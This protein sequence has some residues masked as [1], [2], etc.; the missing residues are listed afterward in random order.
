MSPFSYHGK[1]WRDCAEIWLVVRG[2]LAIRTSARVNV[3]TFKH[4]CSPPLVYR[5]KGILLAVL[6]EENRAS[7]VALGLNCK[8]VVSIFCWTFQVLR[9]AQCS[10]TSTAWPIGQVLAS[11]PIA[12]A[13][14]PGTQC[15]AQCSQFYR[16]VNLATLQV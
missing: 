16:I 15:L 1:S 9:T 7:F 2:L 14:W 3:H 4:I 8:G 6:S 11:W 5:P 12:T 10:F 13:N